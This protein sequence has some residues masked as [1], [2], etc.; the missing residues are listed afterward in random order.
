MLKFFLKVILLIAFIISPFFAPHASAAM[1]K[2]HHHEKKVTSAKLHQFYSQWKGVHY[3]LGG[4]S[5]KGI[6]CSA[7]TQRTF[8]KMNISIP[9]TTREQLARGK[10]VARSKLQPGDLVF[11]KT[12]RHQR[13]VGI[14]VGE[15]KFMHASRKVGVTLSSLANHYWNSRYE[16]SIRVTS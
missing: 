10:P 4:T 12:S 9:R 3:R 1:Q 11:F 7:L 6:D 16:T 5:K 8:R 14:Y 15:G 2:G 13:H